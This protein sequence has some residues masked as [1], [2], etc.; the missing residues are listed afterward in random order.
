MLFTTGE[1]LCWMKVNDSTQTETNIQTDR[2]S[3]PEPI[4]EMN[5]AASADLSAETVALIQI[6]LMDSASRPQAAF[7]YCVLECVCSALCVCV[8]AVV[9]PVCDC[10]S[11]A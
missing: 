9:G 3:A 4:A 1:G 5:S 10:C 2:S 8:W 7:T 6:P 11:A